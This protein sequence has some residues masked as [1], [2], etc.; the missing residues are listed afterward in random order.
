VLPNGVDSVFC[1]NDC[2]G[3]SWQ[4][5]RRIEQNRLPN[6]SHVLQQRMDI[7]WNLHGSF[8]VICSV[9]VPLQLLAWPGEAFACQ[10]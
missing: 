8:H 10:A 4:A 7:R 1:V 2:W 3:E 6:F 5:L 9:V